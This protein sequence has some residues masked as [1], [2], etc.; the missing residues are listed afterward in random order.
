MFEKGFFE[1]MLE[2]RSELY[3]RM[4]DLERFLAD[5]DNSHKCGSYQFA[6]LIAQHQIMQ[7]YLLILDNRIADL[8]SLQE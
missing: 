6:Q 2:E 1:R 8:M 7:A 5:R 3:E 4:E